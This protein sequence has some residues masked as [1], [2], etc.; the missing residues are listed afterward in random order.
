MVMDTNDSILDGLNAQQLEA[1][2]TVDGPLLV[3]SAAGTG[4]TRVITHRIANL[5][6]S[7]IPGDTV[8]ALTFTKKA[9]TE[10]CERVGNLLGQRAK[11]VTCSTF[12]A[13]GFRMV[14]NL[15]TRGLLGSDGKLNVIKQAD[16]YRLMEELISS[17]DKPGSVNAASAP[18]FL[19]RISAAKN[20]GQSPNEFRAHQGDEYGLFAATL[21]G[22][23]QARLEAKNLIDL[24]DMCLIPYRVLSEHSDVQQA[25]S[26]RY[27][28]LM[29]DEFQDT[30]HVQFEL[31]KLILGEHNNLCVVG[32]DDQSIYGFRGADR[33]KI[34]SFT[35]DFPAAKVIILERNYRSGA[36]IIRV[37][38]DVISRAEDQR[39]DKQL[40]AERSSGAPVELNVACG[41]T[42][43][44]QIV[45]NRISGLSGVAHSEMAILCR[46]KKTIDP[47]LDALGDSGI[48]VTVSGNAKKST[49]ASGVRVLTLHESKGLEFPV[50]FLPGLEEN[51][52]PHYNAICEGSDSV[53]EERRLFYVGV[54]RARDRL[55]LSHCQS[56]SGR[57]RSPSRFVETL[58]SGEHIVCNN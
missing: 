45:A 31:L 18:Y 1:V 8:C 34:L 50:V 36:P 32:D 2:Q 37:A 51:S 43:E 3:L 11:G 12:H 20:R 5:V 35:Q 39:F 21:Y 4:K 56:R 48:P 33:K 26:Q 40:V 27:G 29:V 23:Y 44:G 25:Y 46:T 55:F 10:M 30:N 15:Q 7:G 16:Q 47:V 57:V 41:P 6:L 52:M 54:T 28:H 58:T 38:N 17:T 9:A 14:A 53:E 22:K 24:D 19:D 13:L 49:S 42:E